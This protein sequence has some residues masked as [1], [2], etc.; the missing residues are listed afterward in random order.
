MNMNELIYFSLVLIK[1]N[2]IS[3]TVYYIDNSKLIFITD[4][5][6]SH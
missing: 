5:I 4:Q 2:S 6:N 1:E 3:E